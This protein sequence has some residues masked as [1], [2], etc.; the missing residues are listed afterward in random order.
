[1]KF[2]T[3][4]LEEFLARGGRITKLPKASREVELDMIALSVPN[5]GGISSII[6]LDDADLFYGEGKPKKKLNIPKIDITLIPESLRNKLIARLLDEG[7]YEEEIE[8]LQE[9]SDEEEEQDNQEEL[10]VDEED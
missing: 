5:M 7:G 8:D 1:M 9:D 10:L 6:S 3:E 2:R 4:S